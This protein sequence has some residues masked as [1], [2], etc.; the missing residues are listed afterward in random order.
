MGSRKGNEHEIYTFMK[1]VRKE[2]REGGREGN[3]G[4]GKNLMKTI[5]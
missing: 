5:A 1:Y 4:N 2:G 3:G